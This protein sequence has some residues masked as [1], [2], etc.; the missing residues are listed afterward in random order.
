MQ[1]S[2]QCECTRHPLEPLT[3]DEITRAWEIFHARQT[4]DGRIRVVP[5]ALNDSSRSR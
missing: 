1:C 2:R 3:A 4:P 5:I